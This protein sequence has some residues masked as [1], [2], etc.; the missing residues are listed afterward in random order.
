RASAATPAPLDG[1]SV[2]RIRPVPP[3]L[4]HPPTPSA[5][6]LVGQRAKTLLTAW[7]SNALNALTSCRPTA[8]GP[9]TQIASTPMVQLSLVGRASYADACTESSVESGTTNAAR[10]ALCASMAKPVPT[11]C[12]PGGQVALTPRVLVE[13]EGDHA[14]TLSR[15]GI[16]SAHTATAKTYQSFG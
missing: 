1:S 15:P 2:S 10:R 3:L 11:T 12:L 8:A 14:Q 6:L 16:G 13:L 7:L 5:R 4:S 9:S